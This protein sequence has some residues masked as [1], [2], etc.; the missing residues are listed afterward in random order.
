MK[1]EFINMTRVKILIPRQESNPR[2]PKHQA[3]ALS[4]ELTRT[5]GGQRHL[6]ES[7]SYLTGVLHTA[8]LDEEKFFVPRSC[9]VDKLTF[10]IKGE[11][12]ESDSFETCIW[13]D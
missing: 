7:S 2:A 1:G 5:H 8:R 13:P 9:H 3:G 4:T 11:F 12:G 6:T 10:H